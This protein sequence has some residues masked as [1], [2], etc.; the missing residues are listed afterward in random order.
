M[1]WVVWCGVLALTVALVVWG[2]HVWRRHEEEALYEPGPE[3]RSHAKD[4]GYLSDMSNGGGG[5]GF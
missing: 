4:S 5:I 1:V 3:S 2:R